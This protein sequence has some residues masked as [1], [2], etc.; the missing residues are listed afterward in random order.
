MVAKGNALLSLHAAETGIGPAV[1]A[2]SLDADLTLFVV[3]ES[4][5]KTLV[6]N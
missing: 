2:T 6:G 1:W 3:N 4:T 5:K